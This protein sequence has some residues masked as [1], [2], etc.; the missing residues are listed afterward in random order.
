MSG[1]LGTLE[2][3]PAEYRAELSKA[4]VSPLWPYLRNLLPP[5]RPIPATQAH[6]WSYDQIRPLLLKAGE[7]TP[8]EK[9][10]RRVLVLS[11]PGRGTAAMQA[12]ATIY[13]GFQLLLPGEV[14]PNHRHTPS[15]A[16]IVVEGEG[17]FTVVEGEK[18]PME[19]GDVILTPNK[20]WHDHGHAGDKPVVWLDALDL[21]LFVSLEG[22]YSE[23]ADAIQ[24]QRQRPDASQ[25]EYR[26]AGLV[27]SRSNAE[28]VRRFPLLRFPWSRTEQALRDMSLYAGLEIIAVDLVNPETGDDPLPTMGFTALMLSRD[29]IVRPVVRSSSA[30]FH[31]VRGSG[32]SIINGVTFEWKDKD[33]FSA[34]VFATVEHCAEGAA[35]FL[36]EVHDRPLQ[37]RLGYYEEWPN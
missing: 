5:G 10:E 15:A 3:L 24:S 21:P 37:R 26:M 11:D 12:T 7:L 27:P 32:R 20:E 18:L 2:D 13:A 31:V 34:P 35:A 36:I 29:R 17:A 6:H 9:A 22:A 8:V 33:S 4:G 23:G 1:P 19:S 25:V 16:R 14:A 30:V 28:L